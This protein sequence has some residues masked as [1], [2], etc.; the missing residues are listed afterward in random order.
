MRKSTPPACSINYAGIDYH[1]KF[2]VITLGD[3]QGKVV[4]T[5]RLSNDKQVIKRFFGQYDGL[6][7]A[8]ESC[9]GYEWFLDYLKELGLTVHLANPYRTKLIAQSRC[10]T[11]KVD[12]RILMELLAIGFLPTCYQPTP[13]E[14]Q[15][16]E[17][18][19][20]RAH[21][22]RSATR[23]KLQIHSLL[24][25]ENLST[26]VPQPFTPTGRKLLKAVQLSPARQLLLQEQLQMLEFFEQGVQRE[27]K[28]CQQSVKRSS[29]AKLLLTIPGI[30]DLTALLLIAELGDIQRFKSSRQVAAYVGLVPSVRSSADKCYMGSITKQGS[31]HL[32]WMLVQC[33]WQAIRICLPIRSH[34][35][36][37]SKRCGKHAAIVSV[38]RKLLQIA[39]RVLRDKKPFAAELIG[40]Q[41]A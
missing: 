13:E 10:K 34:F 15:L 30:G 31:S 19:R 25:K 4:A 40:Q 38:A 33:A 21:L 29:Q 28:W 36:N 32:R 17:R 35:V 1:K 7:C 18:L 41:S 2:S 26:V 5:E 16:R 27:D 22:V 6:I 12:S 3:A 14:R 37:V 8:V 24:D 39:Y 23:A 20:W 9:R 11:D